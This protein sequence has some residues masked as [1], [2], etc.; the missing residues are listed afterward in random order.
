MPKYVDENG[1]AHFWGNIEDSIN[2]AVPSVNP[3]TFA[4][5]D[6][7]KLQAAINYSK[8]NGYPTISIGREYDITGYQLDV[9][10]GTSFVDDGLTRRKNLTFIG[11][12]AGCIKKDDSGY[13]FTATSYS[14]DYCF[15]NMLFRGSTAKD[16]C[17]VF[18]AAM[19]I[20]VKT[21]GC[22]YD[23]L[24]Y[25]FDG[26]ASMSSAYNMQSINTYGDTATYCSAY[27]IIRTLWDCSFNGATIEGCTNGIVID[28]T[29]NCSVNTLIINDCCIES[30]GGAVDLAIDD[31]TLTL[32]SLKIQDCYFESN[33]TKDIS[34]H[35]SYTYNVALVGNY[36]SSAIE[37]QHCVEAYVVSA[38]WCI[39]RNDASLAS[40]GVFLYFTDSS[41]VEVYGEPNTVR[42]GSESNHTTR[43]HTANRS[44]Y[45]RVGESLAISN[46]VVSGYVD[47]NGTRIVC[48]IPLPK[49]M[50]SG[51]R[52]TFTFT[53]A[54]IIGNGTSNYV[55]SSNVTVDT[56]GI[57]YSQ[58]YLALSLSS[59]TLQN[60]Y[61]YNLRITGT[62]TFAES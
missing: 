31:H 9:T 61:D 15:I 40:N 7:E 62:L 36:F 1:L 30:T 14:G 48:S 6:Y 59:I 18:N 2:A 35:A 20:R 51:L 46:F 21:F 55:T 37:N 49:Q 41:N 42:G 4:G 53:S 32:V 34:I 27:A 26:T 10:K 22:F 50:P 11:F 3:D 25:V 57:N 38:G 45:F 60:S 47:T 5:T 56:A 12:G 28:K 13:I 19:M 52:G 8:S 17:S 23:N 24:K 54:N 16:G 58:L 44:N 29:F 43:L 39:S 33:G